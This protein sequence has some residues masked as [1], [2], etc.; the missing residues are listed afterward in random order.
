[1]P[2]NED[3]REQQNGRGKDQ[4]GSDSINPDVKP[5]AQFLGPRP[6][7]DELKTA[8]VGIVGHE[9]V[10]RGEQRRPGGGRGHGAHQQRLAIGN[11]QQHDGPQ[12]RGKQSC[13]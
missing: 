7:G 6:L 10:H 13:L 2:R 11:E 12:E 1:M 3:A 8:L 5:D 4:G 9:D